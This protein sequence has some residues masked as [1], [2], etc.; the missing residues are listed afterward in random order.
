MIARG[1]AVVWFLCLFNHVFAQEHY[2]RIRV[3]VLDAESN[4]PVP[5]ANVY[6]SQT[7]I[8]GY[9]DANGEIE[10][11]RIPPGTHQ[12][13]ISEI[14]HKLQQRKLIITGE[15]PIY[16]TV[17]LLVKMLEEVQVKAKRD[18]KWYR[19]FARF[20]RLFFGTA[21]FRRCKI[22]NPWVLDFKNEGRN[23][24][25]EADE[26]LKI[27]NNFLGYDLDFTIKTCFFNESK[28]TITGIVRFE[29]KNGDDALMEEWRKNREN[30]YRGSPSHFLH[31]MI[32]NSLN[33]DGYQIYADTTTNDKIIR[34]STLS[35]NIGHT[36][37]R[38]SVG[39]KVKP[40]GRGMYMITF[41]KR[42][43]VH[44]LRKRARPVAYV[45]INHPISWME[46]K[47]RQLTVS[48]QGIVQ[49]PE[50]LTVVGMMGDLNVA[51][52][53]PLNYQ[54][55]YDTPQP[56]FVPL[57]RRMS[58]LER[59]YVQT[60]R[61]Y[62]YNG[63]TMWLK[64]YLSYAVPLLRDTLSQSIYVE[65]LDS[66]NRIVGWKHYAVNE[67]KFY[68]DILLDKKFAPGLYQLKV[69][70]TWMLNFDRRL[71]FSRTIRL[72][73]E[74]EAVRVT[75]NY[76]PPADTLTNI[77]V[78]TDKTSYS[79]REK[80]VVT[81][82]VTDSLGFSTTS[83]L[84]VSVT[85]LE[86][87]VP[88]RTEKTI[89][90]N[91][92]YDELETADTTTSITHNI[93]YGIPFNGRFWLRRKPAQASITVFQENGAVPFGFIT[94]QAG[95]FY[96]SLYFTDTLSLYLRAMSANDKKGIVVMDTL[97][98]RSPSLLFDPLFLDVYS[99]DANRNGHVNFN[100]TT[101][102]DEVTI[103][104]KRIV[105]RP[106]VVRGQ[107]DYQLTGDWLKDHN[108]NDPLLGL[109]MK[110]PGLYY[111]PAVPSIRMLTGFTSF[112]KGGGPLLLVDGMTVTAE[113]IRS[114]PVQTIEYIDVLKFGSATSYG[115]RGAN[116]VIAV[117]TNR[118][119]P[120]DPGDKTFDK[121]NLQE[122]KWVGYSVASTFSSPDYSKPVDNDYV[123]YRATIFWS[124]K[125]TT[126][127]QEPATVTFYAAD[128]ATK[129]RIVVE[130]VTSEGVPVRAE[131][132]VEVVTGR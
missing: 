2:G 127:G 70:T 108:V 31:A 111:D 93:E 1:I 89:L 116:G 49:D 76:R 50:D 36:I 64:G 41:P 42:L 131:K 69:F 39:G 56:L 103:S 7:T 74:N 11:A 25:A 28:F 84:S 85:D 61:D 119:K 6:L 35:A 71:I 102:L 95:R 73:G 106:A 62:Y 121:R 48:S 68:G 86:Q 60:D 9:T 125:V 46:V 3:K 34:G 30:I 114:I 129:Y 122:V 128:L 107:G 23:F 51:D 33:A 45:N 124:P 97:H 91:Y 8:G 88:H 113:D 43:E 65:L 132:I 117:Y 13:I 20:E 83:D 72:L 38:D 18:R 110:I 104:A 66:N 17:K 79:Q 19:Q 32:N 98:P 75:G 52:W 87:A 67:G 10:V 29:E 100:G 130:G 14:S 101:V 92:L 5:Y 4:R 58:L 96:Q 47:N 99:S 63:E 77:S 120:A 105:T 82:D 109:A 112:G 94:D 126:D 22:T 78:Q 59:P 21:H 40:A 53:L 80:I 90:S 16:I 24:I 27:Q 44:Y 81:I 37:L 12:L 118:R 115:S 26:P 57:E 54:Y 123:D 55:P 15:R